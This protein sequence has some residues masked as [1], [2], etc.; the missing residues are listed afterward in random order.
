[1]RA[2]RLFLRVRAVIQYVFR[3]VSTLENTGSEQRAL[4]KFS[5]LDLDLSL[6]H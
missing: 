5:G 4:R 6:L 2:V 3:A 1:M